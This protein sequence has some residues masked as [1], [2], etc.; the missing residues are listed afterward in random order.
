MYVG[1]GNAVVVP[2]RT[3]AEFMGSRRAKRYLRAPV[4]CAMPGFEAEKDQKIA[5][6]AS[7]YRRSWAPVGAAEG[8]DL[9]I[10]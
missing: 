6:F 7:S 2:S 5:G 9:L 10:F 8:C 4:Q 3:N 1:K